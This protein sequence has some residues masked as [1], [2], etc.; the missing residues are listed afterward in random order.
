M[1]DINVSQEVKAQ[2]FSLLR[3][4]HQICI[5]NNIPMVASTVVS[6]TTTPQGQEILKSL[7]TF[8]DSRTGAFDSTIVAASEILKMKEVPPSVIELLMQ[9]NAS[10]RMSGVDVR[11]QEVHVNFH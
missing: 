11:G 6:K 1:K 8:V 5:E 10:A 3:Q 7:S 9:M 4:V 2:L